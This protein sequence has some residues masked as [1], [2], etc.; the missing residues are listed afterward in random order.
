V[1]STPLAV[2]EVVRYYSAQF[3]AAGW[4]L[5]DSASSGGLATHTFAVSY[6]D[7]SSNWLAFLSGQVVP[8]EGT[9]VMQLWGV[10]R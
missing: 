2:S 4:R 9:V 1:L 6:P 3:I 7:A 8:G 10:R 5:V